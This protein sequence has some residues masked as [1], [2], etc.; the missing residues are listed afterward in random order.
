MKNVRVHLVVE[1]RVQGVWYRESTRIKATA[2]DIKGWVKNR[3]DGTVEIIVEGL[4]TDI[5]EFVEWCHT[6]PPR[7]V[8]SKITESSQEF[9]NE[10]DSFNIVF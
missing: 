3:S 7:A 4:D 6:G 10:F 8:V 5:R 1:G 2:I 9:R